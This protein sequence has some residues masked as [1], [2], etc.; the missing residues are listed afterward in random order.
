M[1]YDERRRTMD[2]G[3]AMRDEYGDEECLVNKSGTCIY[4]G[5]I[6]VTPS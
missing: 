5:F 2:D 4:R 3:Q 6:Q 1:K